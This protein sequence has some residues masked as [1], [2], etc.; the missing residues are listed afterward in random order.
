[1]LKHIEL[2]ILAHSKSDTKIFI[3]REKSKEINCTQNQSKMLYSCNVIVMSYVRYA[4]C[5]RK[6]EAHPDFKCREMHPKKKKRVRNQ[7]ENNRKESSQSWKSYL[8]THVFE[9]WCTE[10][11]K[12]Q[13]KK[14][15]HKNESIDNDNDDGRRWGKQIQKINDNLNLQFS[16]NANK[17]Y[18]YLWVAYHG[19][20]CS[21]SPST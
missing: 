8:R 13:S 6:R 21:E 5:E 3:L 2:L 16:S 17:F 7:N 14:G 20:E 4:Q 10:K 11:W 15:T 18:L 1:M 9:L 19:G 12:G